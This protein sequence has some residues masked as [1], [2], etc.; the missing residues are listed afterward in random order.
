MARYLYEVGLKP[1]AYAAF[2]LRY[3]ALRRRMGLPE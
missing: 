1:E 3:Q 2:I